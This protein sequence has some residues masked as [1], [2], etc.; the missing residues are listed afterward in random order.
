M[1]VFA[2]KKDEAQH[3]MF[4]HNSILQIQDQTYLWFM[5]VVG[6]YAVITLPTRT[7]N[8]KMFTQTQMVKQE[9]L[10]FVVFEKHKLTPIIN[11]VYRHR[12]LWKTQYIW[13]IFVFCKMWILESASASSFGLDAEALYESTLID[14]DQKGQKSPT[15]YET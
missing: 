12:S 4:R 5:N 6:C 14:C 9:M 7:Y 3:R 1:Q 15:C 13:S 10:F 8:C 2:C 11:R